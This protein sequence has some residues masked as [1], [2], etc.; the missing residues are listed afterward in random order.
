MD[1]LKISKLTLG[2]VQFGLDYGVAN[3]SGK[4]TFETAKGIISKAFEGGITA[5]DTAAAY[6]ES[7]KIIGRAFAELGI[8]DSV[9]PITKISHIPEGMPDSEVGTLFEMSAR[10]SIDN[11]G[12][13]TLPLLLMHNEL[14]IRHW[15]DLLK[16]RSLGLT[17][18]VGISIDSITVADDALDL[19]EVEAIQVPMNM[20]D[21]RFAGN[22]LAEAKK[23][24][25]A[26]FTRSAFLQ[27]LLVMP[28]SNIKNEVF[29]PVL[30]V[31]RALDDIASTHGMNMPQ[32]CLRHVASHSG[33]DSIL[34]GVDTI[35]QLEQNLAIF[36]KGPLSDALIAEIDAVVPNFPETIL[37]PLLWPSD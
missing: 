34:F 30:P 27:G 25:I 20:L 19:D 31:R 33:V 35:E 14:D 21:G 24:G 29:S 36:A 6:G 3:T 22:F 13:E 4:P 11:L 37:R 32:L 15:D 12:L 2:T 9:T 17:R 7:E 18:R 8:T 23:K 5:F 1:M 28:V 26:I 16:L 10:A